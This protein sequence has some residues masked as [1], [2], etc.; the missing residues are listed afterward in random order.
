MRWMALIF[1]GLTAHSENRNVTARLTIRGEIVSSLTM[2]IESYPIA[3]G[4]MYARI[5]TQVSNSQLG[6]G[7]QEQK[8]LLMGDIGQMRV[9]ANG[10]QI[11]LER[12]ETVLAVNMRTG[13]IVASNATVG[14]NTR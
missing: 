11:E 8:Y 10:T 13:E 14:T 2:Q 7:L 6:N 3:R 4:V 1:L 5:Q 9:V 12:P